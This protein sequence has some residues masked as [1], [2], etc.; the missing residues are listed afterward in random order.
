MAANQY[1]GKYRAK[2][3]DVKDPEKRGRIRVMCP[4]VLGDAKSSWCEPCIP[5]AYDSGGDFAI[6]K[7]NEF[8]WVEFEEGNPNNPIYTGGLWSTNKSPSSSYATGSRLITWGNCIVSMNESSLVLSVGRCSISLSNSEIK[9]NAP[10]ITAGKGFS[11]SNNSVV[12]NT[13]SFSVNDNFKVSNE[14]ATFKSKTYVG[15][16]EVAKLGDE[17]T[18]NITTGKGSITAIK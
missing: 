10:N 3:V 4:K 18:C 9:I 14:E 7:L 13:D 1:F 12:V 16:R 15:G 11:V 17:V 5:V 8:V 6:P 2:V